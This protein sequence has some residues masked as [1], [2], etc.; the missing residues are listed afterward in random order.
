VEK[1]Y[2]VEMRSDTVS[3]NEGNDNESEQNPLD[4]LGYVVNLDPHQTNTGC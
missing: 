1:K 4:S 3:E 2:C